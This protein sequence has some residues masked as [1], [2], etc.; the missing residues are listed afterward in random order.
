MGTTEIGGG[1]EIT[2]SGSKLTLTDE[3]FLVSHASWK[4]GWTE[5][6]SSIYFYTFHSHSMYGQEI[7]QVL[8][9]PENLAFGDEIFKV[10]ER[11]PASI[12]NKGQVWNYSLTNWS[13]QRIQKFKEYWAE[14]PK[15]NMLMLKPAVPGIRNLWTS[16]VTSSLEKLFSRLLIAG[17]VY[18]KIHFCACRTG[19]GH[20]ISPRKEPEPK[21]LYQSSD[22]YW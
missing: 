1:W 16:D 5:S 6:P 15:F 18:E 8:A 2:H 21:D 22:P 9:Q 14:G 12:V 17:L 13:P 11:K 20:L 19:G 3:A 7:H 10:E 4:G